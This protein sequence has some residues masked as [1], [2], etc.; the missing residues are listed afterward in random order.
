MK[1]LFVSSGNNKYG[2]VPFIKSQGESLKANGVELDYFTIKGKGLKGYLANIKPLREKIKKG[3]YDIVHTHYSLTAFVSSLAMIGLNLP[4]VTS[5]MGSDVN[6]NKIEKIFIKSFNLFFWD[7]VIVKSEDMKHKIGINR[8]EIIPNGIN[9]SIFKLMDQSKAKDIVGFDRSKRQVLWLADPK[10]YVKNIE[11]AKEAF[12]IADVIDSELKII[13]G[14]QHHEIPVYM[15]ACDV[16]LLTSRWEG[17]PNVIKEAMACNTPIVT[18]RVGDVK[19]TIGD[20]EGCF[21]VEQNEAEL[22]EAIKDCLQYN[23]RTNGREKIRWLDSNVIA[24]K[25]IKIYKEQNS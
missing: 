19:L 12:K 14:I 8:V 1:V 18:T 11:L 4:Q 22:A 5:L 15:N 20:T 6:S 9:F 3:K 10:R 13:N 16:L 17:S 24:E 21:I 2:I 7:S 25:L 23:K